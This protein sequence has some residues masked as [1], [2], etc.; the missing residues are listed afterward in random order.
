MG[1]GGSIGSGAG[2]GSGAGSG[3]CGLAPWQVAA[4][5]PLLKQLGLANTGD[6]IKNLVNNIVLGLGD[7]LDSDGIK[8]LL[9]T[10]DRLV[11]GLG[12]GGLDTRPAVG[13]VVSILR[14]Q[15]PCLLNT[16]LPLP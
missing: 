15:V 2:T 12:L 1:S 8:Q 14:N 13:E 3:V 9:G 7:L 6:E 5:S 10:V 16:L 11:N 4:L